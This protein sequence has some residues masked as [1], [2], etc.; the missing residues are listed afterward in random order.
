[1]AYSPCPKC[2]TKAQFDELFITM[3]ES[4]VLD[5]A[6]FAVMG[7]GFRLTCNKNSE[8]KWE[9]SEYLMRDLKATGYL[10][11]P[12]WSDSAHD[13]LIGKTVPVRKP[14]KYER[15]AI[16]LLF[17]ILF[18]ESQNFHNNLLPRAQHCICRAMEHL[19]GD[20]VHP[21]TSSYPSTSEGV[22]VEVVTWD[23]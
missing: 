1:M 23:D 4:K 19:E 16:G 11:R 6:G 22:L 15:G 17:D 12:G 18:P 20:K 9:T 21:C 5:T 13:Y 7:P 8:H 14:V 10:V 2:Q 3:S